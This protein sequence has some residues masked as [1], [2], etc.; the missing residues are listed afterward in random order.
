[1]KI[2]KASEEDIKAVARVYVD[3]WKTTYNGLVPNDYLDRLSYEEAE[4][5]WHD[6]FNNENL[7]IKKT[8]VFTNL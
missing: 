1:M 3:A 7:N 8:L 4:Q 2:K 6:F 5:K